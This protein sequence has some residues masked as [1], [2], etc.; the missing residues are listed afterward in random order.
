MTYLTKVSA[1]MVM[2]CLTLTTTWAQEPEALSFFDYLGTLVEGEDG[3][4]DPLTLAEE[5]AAVEAVALEPEVQQTNPGGEPE[6][7][8]VLP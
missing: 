1:C 2:S 3:W 5:A 6:T 4:I 7:E 8:E